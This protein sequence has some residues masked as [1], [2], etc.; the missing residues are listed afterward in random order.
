MEQSD[1]DKL[2]ALRSAWDKSKAVKGEKS[3]KDFDDFYTVFW[4]YGMDGHH[5]LFELNNN[6][7]MQILR[8][9]YTMHGE[10]DGCKVYG[11]EPP[12]KALFGAASCSTSQESRDRGVNKEF[13]Y[14]MIL[15]GIRLGLHPPVLESKAASQVKAVPTSGFEKPT[16]INI[17]GNQ[18]R[19]VCP[20]G[21]GYYHDYDVPFERAPFD[22]YWIP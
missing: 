15:K 1:I 17:T 14:Y 6:M 5:D 21:H 19:F 11:A 12:C 10:C 4:A 18:I 7:L 9:Y 2:L 22:L 16:T 8:E 20:P 13:F 3:Q